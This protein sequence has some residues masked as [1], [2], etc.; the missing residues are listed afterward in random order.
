MI[1]WKK[2]ISNEITLGS[3]GVESSGKDCNGVDE[4]AGWGGKSKASTG[5]CTACG[6]LHIHSALQS[7]E[8]PSVGGFEGWG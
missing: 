6:I 4:A 7:S 1:L 5:G 8:A 2:W 3:D